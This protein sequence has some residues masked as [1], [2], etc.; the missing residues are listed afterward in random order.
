LELKLQPSFA[1]C[2]VRCAD[3]SDMPVTSGNET[4]GLAEVIVE[5]WL[6][7]QSAAA[8]WVKLD[9]DGDPCRTKVA[10]PLVF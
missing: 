4:L 5:A 1:F 2:R 7:I 6:A 9:P 10:P 8:T 3:F